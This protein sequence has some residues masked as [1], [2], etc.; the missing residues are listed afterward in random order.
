MPRLIDLSL[1]LKPGMRGVSVTPA[2]TFAENG[3]N[4]A[5]WSLY[6]HAGTHVDS[7]FHF[8]A[9]PTTIDQMMS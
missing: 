7:P 2:Y 1:S 5:N 8:E 9:A 4:A 3:W 6:S